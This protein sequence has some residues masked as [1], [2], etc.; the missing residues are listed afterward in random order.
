[1][2]PNNSNLR[3]TP[4]EKSLAVSPSSSLNGF[5]DRPESLRSKNALSPPG[6]KIAYKKEK[7]SIALD[8]CDAS[9]KSSMQKRTVSITSPHQ[10]ILVSI[11]VKAGDVVQSGQHVAVMEAMK[12]QFMVESSSNGVV[13]Q[14]LVSEGEAISTGQPLLFIEPLDASTERVAQ[15]KPVDLDAIRPDLQE[16]RERHA[17]GLDE[18]RQEAVE[19]RRKGGQRTA[20]ENVADLCDAESFIEYGALTLAGQRR[21]RSLEELITLSPADC[22][23]AGIGHIHRALFP[24]EPSR[25]MVQ[26]DHYPV[27]APTQGL[28]HH[29]NTARLFPPAQQSN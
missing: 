21:R 9:R 17:A 2:S 24:D 23:V 5:S 12:M 3:L 25:S 27:F 26:A 18:S 11:A 14:I 16:A 8:L 4:R 15:A 19:R 22:L 28:K 13:R 20:R 1:M 29:K 7:T 6:D 10:G